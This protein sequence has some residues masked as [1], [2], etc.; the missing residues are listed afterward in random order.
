MRH[1]KKETIGIGIAALVMVLFLSG[2]AFSEWG[3]GNLKIY[4]EFSV[5]ETYRS[6]IYQTQTN[7]QS[8]WITTTRA[9]GRLE[10]K[11]GPHKLTLGYNAGWLAYANNSSN[12][13]WD[14]NAMSLLNMNFPGGLEVNL[15][16]RFIKSTIEQTAT[17]THPRP[18]ER[19][20]TDF[21]TAYKFA[22]RWKIQALY[23][24]E[25]LSFD[26]Q[27]D[28]AQ[29][30]WQNLY[31]GQMYYRFTARTSA[32]VEYDYV[33][34]TFQNNRASNSYS[35]NVYGGFSFDPAG[36]LRG[37]AKVGYGWK[38]FD[39]TMPNRN[40]KPDNWI[41]AINLVDEFSKS[42]SLSFNATR[43]LYDDSDF[44]NA[45]YLGTGLGATFQHFFTGKLGGTATAIYRY[46]T[47]LDYNADPVTGLMKKRIDKRWDLGLG[48]IYKMNRWLETR[49]E[50]TYITKN[51]N[52]ETY[53]FDE[54]RVMFRI[55]VTP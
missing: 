38:Q 35:N 28:V 44:G 27:A 26:H 48:A 2:T 40:N 34:K 15:G 25:Q 37:D 49:L 5:A 14:H 33:T 19:S 32:L 46:N 20:Y 23:N 3:Y 36:R 51:S 24:R 11:F 50:Y 55:I 29:D 6:N 22:D 39:N 30:Y 18:Y 13:Y 1:R 7:R 41:M 54:N 17:V 52:F 12:N 10:Y 31:G 8:D 47:Y 45:S 53:S 43:S 4:P 16:S 42:T 21:S 9:G